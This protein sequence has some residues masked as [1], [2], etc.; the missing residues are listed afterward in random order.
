MIRPPSL[1]WK[2]VLSSSGV[3]Q[4]NTTEWGLQS[5]VIRC[6]CPGESYMKWQQKDD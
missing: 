3:Q 4:K 1:C 5:E 6:I 2:T